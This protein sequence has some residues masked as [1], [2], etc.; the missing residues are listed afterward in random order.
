MTQLRWM[1]GGDLNQPVEPVR[2]MLDAPHAYGQHPM[3]V[4]WSTGWGAQP[5][6]RAVPHADHKVLRLVHGATTTAVVNA[7]WQWGGDRDLL[8]AVA[9]WADVLL[10]VECRTRSNDPL[11][12]R[13]FIG[14]THRVR[15]SLSDSAHAGSAIAVRR[16]PALRIQWSSL[17]QLSPRGAG[18][19]ARY[20][21]TAQLLDHGHPTRYGAAHLALGATGVQDDGERELR[22]WVARARR[23]RRT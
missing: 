3:G 19:Q 8:Q 13:Q 5:S 20:L 14:K 21:R 1:L 12:V 22:A 10:M 15:Q 17:S 9:E 11:P 6:A 18:V 23:A 2:R 16:D 4:L 7:T